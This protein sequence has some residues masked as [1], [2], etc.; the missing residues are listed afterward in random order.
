MVDIIFF[1]TQNFFTTKF[2]LDLIFFRTLKFLHQKFFFGKK[3]FWIQNFSGQTFFGLG[4]RPELELWLGWHEL[5]CPPVRQNICNNGIFLGPKYLLNLIFFWTQNF[6]HPK[7]YIFFRT[8]KFFGP[9]IF[10]AQHFLV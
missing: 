10:R 3:N 5:T 6:V 2:F 8:N 7:F 4:L 1:W 9:N